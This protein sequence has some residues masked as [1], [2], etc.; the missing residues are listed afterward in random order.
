[1]SSPLKAVSRQGSAQI[2]GHPSSFLPHSVAALQPRA[3]TA[4]L[5]S[6]LCHCMSPCL[7]SEGSE[8]V[9]ALIKDLMLLRALLNPGLFFY[10]RKG[11]GTMEMYGSV[12]ARGTP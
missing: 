4:R 9:Q 10:P 3:L 8:M 2:V 5:S 12:G 1:M 6:D 11:C 7:A